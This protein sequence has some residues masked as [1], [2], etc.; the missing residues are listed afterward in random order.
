[1][2]KNKK[3]FDIALLSRL[4]PYL[5]KYFGLALL[6][7]VFLIIVDV[8]GVLKPYLIKPVLII[9]YLKVISGALS[10]SV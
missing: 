10:P 8:S 3:T 5:K 1:M 9:T 4:L 6:S 7:F 2:D